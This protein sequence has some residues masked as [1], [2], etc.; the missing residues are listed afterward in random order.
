MQ[1]L[2]TATHRLCDAGVNVDVAVLYIVLCVDVVSYHINSTQQFIME[3]TFSSPA[4]L[5]SVTPELQAQIDAAVAAL[6]AAHRRAPYKGEIVDS[7]EAALQRLQD[8]AFTHGFAIAIESGSKNRVRF[9]CVHHKKKTKNCRKTAEDDRVR[10]KTKTQSK[11][12]QFELYISQQ[13]RLGGQWGIGSTCL[14]H[15]HA[16][17]PDPFQYIQHRSKRPRYSDALAAAT[18]HLG[19]ISYKASA[20]ILHKDGLELDRKQY[21]NLRRQ[22]SSGRELTR[23]AELELLLGDLEQEGLHPR[24]RSEYILDEQGLPT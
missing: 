4:S 23:Q 19:V 21:N 18:T 6:P 9:E 20:A 7:K 2:H 24:V 14:H 17:N 11:D 10:V 1:A 5:S 12:C 22:A 3:P 8:W 16:P 13:K 15:N